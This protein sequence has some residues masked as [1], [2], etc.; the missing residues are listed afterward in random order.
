[1]LVYAPGKR[2]SAAEALKHPYFDDLKKLK[3]SLKKTAK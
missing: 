3:H 1:M 2:V